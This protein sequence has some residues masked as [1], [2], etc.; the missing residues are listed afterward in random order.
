MHPRLRQPCIIMSQILSLVASACSLGPARPASGE[1]E[2]LLHIEN[3]QFE[4]LTVYLV[5]NGLPL[6][7]GTVAG[8]D[9]RTLRIADSYL[10][11]VGELA[12][13]AE[14]RSSQRVLM[15]PMFDVDRGQSLRWVIRGSGA[16]SSFSVR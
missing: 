2:I 12:L 1:A 7:I 11:R 9:T 6:R 3:Q 15:S 4:D 5:R 8:L 13:R 14:A 10:S 16:L